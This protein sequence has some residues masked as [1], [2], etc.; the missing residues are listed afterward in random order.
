MSYYR[1]MENTTEKPKAIT[2]KTKVELSFRQWMRIINYYAMSVCGITV[3][4]ISDWCWRDEFC[5]DMTTLENHINNARESFETFLSDVEPGHYN[6]M[7][8]EFPKLTEELLKNND[9]L[10]KVVA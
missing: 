1:G 8:D 9:L 4:H 7:V 10:G 6:Q 3:S 5:E 2:K